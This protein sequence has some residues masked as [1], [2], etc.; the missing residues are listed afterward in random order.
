MIHYIVHLCALHLSLWVLYFII[1]K[2]V[3]VSSW[4]L[5]Y[6][7][8]EKK[9][10]ISQVMLTRH[11]L[12][13]DYIHKFLYFLQHRTKIR[14]HIVNQ[15]SFTINS[16]VQCMYIG[17]LSRFLLWSNLV[18][19]GAHARCP[20]R[21]NTN[22]LSPM[23]IMLQKNTNNIDDVLQ[24][25]FWMIN[26]TT[27]TTN[28]HQ[29]LLLHAHNILAKAWFIPSTNTA[30]WRAKYLLDHTHYMPLMF[31]DIQFAY[32]REVFPVLIMLSLWAH[33][34]LLTLQLVLQLHWT[35][36]TCTSTCFGYKK[37]N[38]WIMPL[39]FGYL[40]LLQP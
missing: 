27:T 6:F 12:P 10:L 20:V 33:Y 38:F 34:L 9:N 15:Q 4:E 19:C 23:Y 5:A 40:H 35:S 32:D 28:N 31:H 30:N 25:K 1:F 39:Q 36:I 21:K 11:I 29:A 2:V 22:T 26:R 7:S 17:I 16:N 37:C 18:P 24:H 13:S 8:M 3:K 14:R